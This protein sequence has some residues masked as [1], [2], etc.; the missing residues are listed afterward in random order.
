VTCNGSLELQTLAGT[1]EVRLSACCESPPIT[2]PDAVEDR[3][4][5]WRLLID[6]GGFRPWERPVITRPVGS[7][8]GIPK[9]GDPAP[10]PGNTIPDL[11]P[12]DPP[13]PP[14]PPGGGPWDSDSKGTPGTI[15]FPGGIYGE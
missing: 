14:P 5:V 4:G 1:G 8:T 6:A 12:P 13:P 10:T 7:F 11:E 2:P 15:T 3:R 9:T